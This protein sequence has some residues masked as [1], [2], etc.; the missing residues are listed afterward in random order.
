MKLNKFAILGALALGLCTSAFAQTDYTPVTFS[1]TA[2]YVNTVT[3][4][5]YYSMSGGHLN[6]NPALTKS[7]PGAYAINNAGILKKIGSFLNTNLTGFVLALDNSTGHLVV[8]SGTNAV[9]DLSNGVTVQ[10]TNVPPYSYTV[11]ASTIVPRNAT[12]V[13]TSG[14]SSSTNF[15]V[16]GSI[17]L[18]GFTLTLSDTYADNYTVSIAGGVGTFTSVLTG[19]QTYKESLNVKVFGTFSDNVE[20]VSGVISGS[21]TAAGGPSSQVPVSFSIWDVLNF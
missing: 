3:V 1:L 18:P 7:I 20:G 21:V 5:G 13:V 15:N 19:T 9:L 4:P 17:T 8:L 10:D 14:T 6:Y 11:T 2:S 12:L 16:A